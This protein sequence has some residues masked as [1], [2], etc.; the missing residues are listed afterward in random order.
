MLAHFDQ[1]RPLWIDLDASRE[2]G[3]GVQI[4]H[5]K[6][7]Y[8]AS[9]GTKWPSRTAIEP[10]MFLLRM[11]TAVEKNYWSTELE[12]AGFVWV[13]KK[14]RYLVE[15]SRYPVIIQTDHSVILDIMKQSSITSTT[16]TLR[17]NVRLVRVSQYLRQFQLDVRHKP[18]KDHIVPDVLSRLATATESDL[19]DDHSELD[20][21]YGRTTQAM[22]PKDQLYAYT[23]SMVSMEEG[24][25]KR[26]LAGY[27]SDPHWKRIATMIDANSEGAELSFVRGTDPDLIFHKNKFTG[28]ERLCIPQSMIKEVLAIAHGDGHPG[29]ERCFDTVSKSWYIHGLTKQLRDYIRHCPDCLLLQ[30]R[31][32]QPYGSLQ[33]IECPAVPF[34]TLTIDFILGLPISEEGFDCAM[35]VVDKFTKRCTFVPGKS[36]WTAGEWATALLDRLAIGDWGTPKALLSDRDPKFL[37][38]LWKAIFEKLDVKLLYSTAYHPQT[39]G[40]TERMNQTAEIGLRFYLHTLLKPSAW[41]SVLPRLQAL[42]NNSQSSATTKAPN[43]ISYGFALNKP[44]DLLSSSLLPNQVQARIEA[45][46]AISFAQVYQKFHYDRRHQPMYFRVG[47]KV[48]LRLHK[49]YSIPQPVGMTK[50]AKLGQQYVG[51]FDIVARIGKQAYRLD[52]PGYWRVHPVFSIAQLEPWPGTDLFDRPLPAE[53]ASVFVEGDTAEWKSYEVESLLNK[54]I[55]RRG[56]GESIDYLVRWRGYGPQYDMWY[57][58]KHLDNAADLIRDYEDQSWLELATQGP[59]LLDIPMAPP[60]IEPRLPSDHNVLRKPSARAP[61]LLMELQDLQPIKQ[62]PLPIAAQP[63]QAQPTITQ[64]PTDAAPRRSQRLLLILS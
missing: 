5:V 9:P 15:S 29:F 60:L 52:I 42:L 3:F 45:A 11:L 38:D 20:A 1:D 46:D 35:T 58:V 8:V 53:P 2:W 13:I 24:F 41:P 40:T 48:L 34:E 57:N 54:R 18:G 50:E 43:E 63:E 26:L 51:P 31:R 10:V 49:G 32:H 6:K 44:I 62:A 21:L 28:V 12:I 22:H 36:T 17:M 61:R 27:D 4:F 30:T 55:R 7:D 64:P 56:K 39:D 23:A 59:A 14:V 33:P 47:D 37:S 25:R 16:S 19:A